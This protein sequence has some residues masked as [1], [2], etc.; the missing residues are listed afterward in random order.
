MEALLSAYDSDEDSK[1]QEVTTSEPEEEVSPVAFGPPPNGAPV[2][3]LWLPYP[4]FARLL[5]HRDE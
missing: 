5:V 2:F 3:L 1:T 4:D